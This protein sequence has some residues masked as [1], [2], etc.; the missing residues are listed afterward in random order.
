MIPCCSCSLLSSTISLSLRARTPLFSSNPS[1]NHILPAA[2]LS[3]PPPR[4]FLRRCRRRGSSSDPN[5]ESI[6]E[7]RF[8]FQHESRGGG[9]GQDRRRRWWSDRNN[10]EEDGLEEEF[11]PSDDEDDDGEQLWD[12]IWIFKV[13]RGY[14]YMLPAIIASMLLATGPK[15]FLLA[16]AVPL[17]QSVISLA[18]D[19][20]WGPRGQEEPTI[21]PSRTRGKPSSKFSADFRNRE[22]DESS[23][24]SGGREDSPSWAATDAESNDGKE[25]GSG[26][27]SFGGWDEL[28][29]E[30]ERARWRRARSE[31]PSRSRSPGV[32]MG[33]L[34][35]EGRRY[36]GAP[37]LLRLLIAVFPFLGS[38]M[39]ML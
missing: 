7:G 28:D 10:T 15:A 35:M 11:G 17:G 37:L 2:S 9:L 20:L 22:Q 32:K 38:W 26:R 31:R 18:I 3:F 39:R 16:L 14:G 8:G 30:G 24:E 1:S 19:K 4:R 36:E 5:A 29:R 12:K 6:R 25:A 13:F 27:R 23:D 21:G 33:K 34:S